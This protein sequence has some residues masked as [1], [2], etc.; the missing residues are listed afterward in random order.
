MNITK[1]TDFLTGKNVHGYYQIYNKTQWLSKSEMEKFKL[2]KFKKLVRHCYENVPYYRDYMKANK[3]VPDMISSLE[4]ISLF[5]IINKEIIKDN[6]AQFIPVNL[7]LLKNVKTSQTG[8]YYGKYSLREQMHI[9]VQ[10]GIYE[11]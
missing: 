11:V 2:E 3:I 10:L 7:K 5:A 4:Q 8:W 1:L 6:Y 9:E